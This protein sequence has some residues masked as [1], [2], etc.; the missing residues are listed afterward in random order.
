MLEV[1]FR[2][3]EHGMNPK[4]EKYHSLNPYYVSLLQD[5]KKGGNNMTFVNNPKPLK[6]VGAEAWKPHPANPQ[7]NLSEVFR[8]QPHGKSFEC[9]DGA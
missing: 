1:S 6:L 8:K 5:L 4:H 2:T 7:Y 9:Y 3:S